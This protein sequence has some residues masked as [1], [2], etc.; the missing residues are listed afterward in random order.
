MDR[1]YLLRSPF[2]AANA[3]RLIAKAIDLTL[4]LAVSFLFYPFG[5]ILAVA[6][7]SVCDAIGAGQS[8]GKR[9]IGFCVISLEDGSPCSLKQSLIRNL[10]ITLPLAFLIFPILGWVL[11]FILSCILFGFEAYLILKL[12]SG[13]RLGDVIADTT[14]LSMTGNSVVVKKPQLSW[15]GPESS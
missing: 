5:V 12:D 2:R 13:H 14:V 6:Y 8:L 10:P 11:C 1:N 4:M 9:Y 3:A 15:F 7:G